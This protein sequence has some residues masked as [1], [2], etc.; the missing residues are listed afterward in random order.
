MG[1]GTLPVSDGAITQLARVVAWH[2]AC[3]VH[4]GFDKIMWPPGSPLAACG[5]VWPHVPEIDGKLLDSLERDARAAFA[6][7]GGHD[8]CS[9]ALLPPEESA[10]APDWAQPLLD[11]LAPEVAPEKT[12]LIGENKAAGDERKHSLVMRPSID[13]RSMQWGTQELTFTETQA[14]CVR[15]L[16]DAKQNGTPEL[17]Q[18]TVLGEAESAMADNKKPQLRKLFTGHPA[19]GT[20]IVKGSTKGTYRLADPAS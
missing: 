7:L 16:W 14:A 4:Y 8:G 6:E 9:G 3:I 5:W 11:K 20:L 2:T 13:F 15:V 19:W 10:H 17:S 12:A 1:Q 18:V